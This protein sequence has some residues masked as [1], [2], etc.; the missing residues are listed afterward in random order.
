MDANA[1]QLLATGELYFF[2]YFIQESKSLLLIIL[3]SQFYQSNLLT[4]NIKG[5]SDK[6]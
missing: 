6:N 1:S 4:L 2:S 5:D 3:N